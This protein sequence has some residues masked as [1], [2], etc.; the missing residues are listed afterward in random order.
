MKELIKLES[1][2]GTSFFSVFMML[3][4]LT[5]KEMKEAAGE[6][7]TEAFSIIAGDDRET[8]FAYKDE[9]ERLCN[10]AINKL[11]KDESFGKEVESNIQKK[12][13]ELERYVDAIAKKRISNATD[14][15]LIRILDGFYEKVED[16]R[17]WAWIPNFLN[18]TDNNILVLAK[19]N[20]E[21]TKM[22]KHELN[23]AFPKLSAP[24]KMMTYNKA[25]MA[26]LNLII[27]L[28]RENKLKLFKEDI[29]AIKNRIDKRTLNKLQKYLNKYSFLIYY[30][31]GPEMSMDD[32]IMSIKEKLDMDPECKKEELENNNKEIRKEQKELIRRYNLKKKD[33][34]LIEEVKRMTFLK[35]YRKEYLIYSNYKIRIAQDEIAKRLKTDYDTIKNLLPEEI[36]YHLKKKK[37]IA[38]DFN[39]RF[40]EFITAHKN[41]KV[42]V[43]VDKDK[44]TKM[45]ELINKKEEAEVEIKGQTA[46]PGYAKGIVKILE[47]RDE[48]KKF[49]KGD[50]LVSR[51]TNPEIVIAMEK[52]AAIVTDV[53]GITCH[54]AIVS[55][56]MKK[57]CVIGTKNASKILKDG[58]YVEVD[59]NNGIVR[60]L[61]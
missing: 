18:Y 36:K 19:K 45:R 50:V 29:N 3:K 24:T 25:N 30:Y 38:N 1:F 60:K 42:S 20:L 54:A 35:A 53:G 2:R 13:E 48:M 37:M 11:L 14:E 51:S 46:Y 28:K 8:I 12:C 9:W 26:L 61:N 41:G 33:L 23:H 32:L 34:F 5:K 47:F 40:N 21:R 57:P 10:S 6:R 22:P 16:L 15:E 27:E 4:V 58:D 52:S 17:I 56:E 31:R 39:H 44:I 49:N 59:A 55:R 7:L 43:C